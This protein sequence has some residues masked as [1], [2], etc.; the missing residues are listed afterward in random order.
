MTAEEIAAIR[1]WAERHYNDWNAEPIAAI[2]L[3]GVVSRLLYEV[4]ALRTA[5]TLLADHLASLAE[6]AETA[7]AERDELRRTIALAYG[8]V[9]EVH[10]DDR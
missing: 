1:G 10:N 6:R 9:T 5:Y 7:E 2:A 8:Q 3:Q 4:T